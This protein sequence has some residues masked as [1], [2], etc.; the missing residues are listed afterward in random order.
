KKFGQNFLLDSNLTD[1]IVRSAGN[2]N[3]CHVFEIGPG[4]G[5]LT[6][7]LLRSDAKKVT[8]IEFDPRVID[9]LKHLQDAAGDKFILLYQ[10][11]LVSDLTEMS[12]APRAIV[13][14]L[15]Y[16]IATPLL[17]NWLSQIR[18][19]HNA[20]RSMTLM[21]QKEVAQRITADVGDKH[22]GRLAVL[23]QWLC[24]VKKSFDVPASAF[25]PPPKV[26]SSIAHFVPKTLDEE[27]PQFETI[28]KIT[29]A[30]FGQRRK[31]I[32]SSL[33]QYTEFFEAVGLDE[34]K[35]AENLS[36]EDYIRLAKAIEKNS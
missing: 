35:R 21:F 13:A 7:S 16:N 31:M 18:V 36:V 9:A 11:A 3:A 2:L 23:C 22:Y 1:K 19:D 10:D 28:E 17:V 15:P 4:P 6:R 29:A 8:A 32:R 20:Y 33:K 34:T 25:T 24:E 27:A 14:N 26:T 5:G 30:A 12:E